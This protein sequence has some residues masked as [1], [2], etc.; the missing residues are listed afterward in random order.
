MRY[1][2]INLFNGVEGEDG[3]ASAQD[4][5]DDAVRTYVAVQD[6][7]AL[8]VGIGDENGPICE[9]SIRDGAWV[10]GE[11]TLTRTQTEIGRRYREMT[12]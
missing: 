7:F 2:W 12:K 11:P 10:E 5:R 6:G 3:F 9:G 1:H 4:A 8:H